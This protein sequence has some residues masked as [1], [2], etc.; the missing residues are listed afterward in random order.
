MT[1]SRGRGCAYIKVTAS[2][3]WAEPSG[4][5]GCWSQIVKTLSVG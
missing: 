4:S 2:L 1:L 5:Q 3:L